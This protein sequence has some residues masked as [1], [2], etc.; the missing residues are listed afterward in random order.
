LPIC[1][2]YTLVLCCKIFRLYK[3][4]IISENWNMIPNCI[5]L[6]DLICHKIIKKYIMHAANHHWKLSIIF[7]CYKRGNKIENGLNF[8]DT[9]PSLYTFFL[10][11]L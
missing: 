4:A 9:L 6:I 3:Y 7:Y 8:D 10:L 2:R 11:A 5:C 1:Y